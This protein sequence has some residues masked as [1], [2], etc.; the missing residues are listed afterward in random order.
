MHWFTHPPYLRWALAAAI[1]T[2]AFAVELRPTSTEAYPFAATTLVAGQIVGPGAIEYRDVSSNLLPPVTELGYA[3]R[4]I[5]VGEPLT[6]ATM[7]R[8]SVIPDDWWIVAV[9]L[10]THVV[11][12]SEARLVTTLSVIDVI[13]ASP[14]RSDGFDVRTFGTVAV[15][16]AAA[17][18]VAL[19]AASDAVVVLVRP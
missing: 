10:P 12:G 15:P 8:G 2:A 19:A 3:A 6:P 11:P 13:V 16:P 18:E 14:G 4:D 9:P 5:A 17:A 7:T 1:V